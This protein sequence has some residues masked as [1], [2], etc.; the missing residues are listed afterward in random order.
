MSQHRTPY[1]VRELIAV[2]DPELEEIAQA[3]FART[4]VPTDAVQLI[5]NAIAERLDSAIAGWIGDDSLSLAE[6]RK[7]TDGARLLYPDDEDG[8]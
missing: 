6:Q 1:T 5:R 3:L 7:R 2:I 4:L 8:L